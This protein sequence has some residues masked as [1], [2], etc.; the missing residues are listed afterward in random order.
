MTKLTNNFDEHQQPSIT[1]QTGDCCGPEC[2]AGSGAPLGEAAIK[3][4]VREHYSQVAQAGCGCGPSCCADLTEPLID[5]GDVDAQIMIGANLGLG[6]GIPTAHARLQPG[7]TVLDLGS[8]AGIDV[9]IAARAV[10]PTGHV[11]GVDMTPE[12]VARARSNASSGAYTNVEFRLGEIE[13]LP[14]AAGTIDVVLSNCVINLVP[15]KRRVYAEIWRVLQPAARFCIS[16]V[17]TYGA[18]PAAVRNDAE[19]WA[20]C[21]AGAMDR[22]E[23]F[24]LVSA[25]GFEITVKSEVIYDAFKGADYGIASVTIEG[26]KTIRAA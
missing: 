1:L 18:I 24:Q 6:C 3:A 16:D 12:M 19:L 13:H 17:V 2:C 22:T 4:A 5:Y 25:A 26:R 11:I 8:G 20:G 9:F 23:Y 15:D 7:D 14:V 21:I 10:G